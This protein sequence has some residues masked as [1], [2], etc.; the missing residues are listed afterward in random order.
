M[1]FIPILFIIITIISV[2][3]RAASKSAS[4][5][6]PARPA[7]PPLS[8]D[9][10]AQAKTP[11]TPQYYAEGQGA[12]LESRLSDPYQAAYEV[13]QPAFDMSKPALGVSLEMGDLPEDAQVGVK[14]S[15]ISQ[16]IKP[17]NMDL[18]EL[19]PDIPLRD[20]GDAAPLPA[21]VVFDRI[22]FLTDRTEFVKAV[23]YSEILRP[24]FRSR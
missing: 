20:A 18:S 6:Q 11:Q 8:V 2:V 19:K 17:V 24:K 14:S 13:S 21:A 4:K 1:E 16:D 7:F 3:V 9:M 12:S 10:P 15:D 5:S 22:R 23:I